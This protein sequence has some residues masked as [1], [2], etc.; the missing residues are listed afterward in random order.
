M[1][2]ANKFTCPHCGT[3]LKSVRGVRIGRQIKCVK[4][5]TA[6]TVRAEDADDADQAAG[7]DVSRLGIVLGG[8]LLYLAGGT[9]LGVYCFATNVQKP[10]PTAAVA[11]NAPAI[12]EKGGGDW[13]AP[14]AAATA[15]Q[16]S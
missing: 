8:L 2:R 3:S 9:V 7:V 14:T 4:C 15:G 12:E 13:T 6:F 10:E 5:G 11:S 16:A 1:D